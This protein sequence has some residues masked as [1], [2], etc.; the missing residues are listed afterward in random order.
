MNVWVKLMTLFHVMAISCRDIAYLGRVLS[1]E[2][3]L[4]GKQDVHAHIF[5]PHPF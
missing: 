5:R 3:G 1:G 4:G 2:I